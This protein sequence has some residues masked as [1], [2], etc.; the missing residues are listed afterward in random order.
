MASE[1]RPLILVRGFGGA[2][3]SDEQ[4]SPYQGFNDGTVYGN[5]RGENYIYEGFVLRA[6]KSPTHP[7]QDATNVVG[8]YSNSVDAPPVPSDIDPDLLEGTVVLDPS[9]EARV[10]AN[11][12]AGT[13]WIYRYYDLR[14]RALERYGQ[15]LARLV[16]LI[17]RS[18]ARHGEE[19]RGVDIVAHSMG[20]LVTREGVLAIDAAEKGSAERKVH[21]IV[22]LGTPH[23]GISFQRTPDW[24]LRVLPKVN[25]AGDELASFTPDST[26]FLD[27]NDVFDTRRILTVVGTDFRSYSIGVTTALNRLSNLFDE[28]NMVYNRSDGL[29]KQ[30]S[31]QLPDAPR[32]FVHKCHGGRDSLVTS[33]EAYEIAMR[34]FHGTHRVSLSLEDA[35]I[36]RGGDWFGRSEFYFGVSIKPRY[37][38]FELF[39]QSVEAQN[40]YGPFH[41]KDLSDDLPALADELR[42]P[43]AE[44]GD[45]TTG[46]AGPDRLI[47]EG[48]VDGRV[49][50]EQVYGLVFRADFYLGERDSFGIGFS[51]NVVYRKQYYIQAF[52]GATPQIFVH[53]GERYLAG[54]EALTQ[55]QLQ[56]RA[57]TGARDEIQ[58]AQPVAGSPGYWTF[59]IGGTG[60]SGRFRIGIVP[61]A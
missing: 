7:Y 29:V 43:L 19:F 36:T 16:E 24:L 41:E 50:P 4:A 14:P 51:D 39:H 9:V 53:T 56:Q 1:L 42:K 23:R 12:V 18:A 5:R 61:E 59:D 6:L 2:D 49:K 27:W 10:L 25:D 47:W 11:G 48:W 45:R 38:D 3:V 60:F 37:V 44:Y 57:G 28:G 15:G 52:P 8:F 31:A 58:A 21:R 54:P 33:R 17:E 20:G 35:K 26:R 55:E 30:A 46:W 40:C 32:T 34:F 13:I 22:T